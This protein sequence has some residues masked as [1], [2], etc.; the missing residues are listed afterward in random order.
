MKVSGFTI[1]RNAVRFD[2]PVVESI[3]SILPMCDE[4][5]VLV[6]QGDDGTSELVSAIDPKVR[7]IPSVWDDGLREGGLVLAVET[8]KARS[9]IAVDSDWAFYIQADE[10]VHEE[11]LDA[12]RTAMIRHRDDRRVQGLLFDYVHFYGSYHLVG[13]PN[14][15]Y[16]REVRI[17]RNYPTIRS[18]KDAQGFR[19]TSGEKLRVRPSGGR[20][21]HYGWVKEPKVM[22][23]KQRNFHRLW[24]AD[25]WV[26][27]RYPEG[28]DF[29]FRRTLF[30]ERF[31][32]THPKVMQ[33]RIARQA[34][35]YEPPAG[36]NR[37]GLKDLLKHWVQ[38]LTGWRPGEY[39]NFKRL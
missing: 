5:V 1:A 16:A 11:D 35:K 23:R 8:D 31:A 24:H 33:D 2:Y 12:I 39:R 25:Q 38:R 26:D 30:L 36:S 13:D 21:F 15:W 28:E 3:R 34:L 18:W 20:I 10:V 4:V 32:G 9:A 14:R 22:Q 6:G 37:R 7:V 19:T 27:E 29:D 17:V